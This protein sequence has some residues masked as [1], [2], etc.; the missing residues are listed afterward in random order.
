MEHVQP[1]DRRAQRPLYLI[2]HPLRLVPAS[3]VAASLRQPQRRLL[4]APLLGRLL[5]GAAPRA[6]RGV[7]ARVAQG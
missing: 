1:A 7:H 4:A 5:A 2:R 3:R 6:V